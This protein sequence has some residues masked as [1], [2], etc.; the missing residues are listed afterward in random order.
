MRG[1][2][3]LIAF[4]ILVMSVRCT[5]YDPGMREWQA[6]ISLEDNNASEAGEADNIDSIT[7][8]GPGGR[9]DIRYY[10]LFDA[11]TVDPDVLN[12]S[13]NQPVD[14]TVVICELDN[15]TAKLIDGFC[16]IYSCEQGYGNCDGEDATGCEK[17]LD[18]TT[19]CGACGALC[20]FENATATCLSGICAL[21]RCNQ[22]FGD[23]NN[24]P[25]DGCETSLNTLTNC[26]ACNN[27]CT[28]PEN[29]D[30][31]CQNG[32]CTATACDKGWDSCDNDPNTFCE[33]RIDTVENCGRCGQAC[34]SKTSN[35]CRNGSCV[36]GFIGGKCRSWEWC[37]LGLCLPWPCIIDDD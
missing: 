1:F 18:D 30:V 22:G 15:A 23:C 21:E 12:A 27:T 6:T 7:K 10:E 16:V 9:F 25:K 34:N 35:R 36:C 37:C 14:A 32:T 20:S 5:A 17:R 8:F 28:I 13:E 29:G 33:T 4:I 31:T 26:G 11:N 3:S 19:D 2:C 24:D